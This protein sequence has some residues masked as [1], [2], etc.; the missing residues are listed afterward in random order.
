M[1]VWQFDGQWWRISVQ[2]RSESGIV[3]SFTSVAEPENE[4]S[5]PTFHWSE[6]GGVV[7]TGTGGPLPTEMTWWSVSVAFEVS[8]TWRPT[9]TLPMAEYVRR[10]VF[11]VASSYC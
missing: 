7:I 8:V 5:S 3:P 9:L 4:M 6:A 10:V 11:E 1:C 2:V